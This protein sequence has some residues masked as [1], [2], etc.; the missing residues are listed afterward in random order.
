M[1]QG[2]RRLAAL[3]WLLWAL[4]A[5]AA[6]AV[7]PSPPARWAGLV[8]PLFHNLGSQQGLGN[9]I[10]TALAQDRDGFL[11]V[12]TQGGL[13]RWDGY[14]FRNY[15]S[16]PG[17]SRTL[18]DNFVGPL[19]V[20]A[21]GRL[22]IGT[23]SGG[24]ARYEPGSDSFVT[25]GVDNA[26]LA[27]PGV[28][29]I[30][31]DGAGGLWVGSDQG[32]DHLRGLADPARTRAAH[33][34]AGGAH[35]LPSKVVK[36]L[37]RD[38]AGTLWVGT[39][40]GLARYDPRLGGFVGVR[41]PT[42]TG[43]APCVDALFQDSDGQLWIGTNG[44][45]LFVLDPRGGA[46][47]RFAPG[48]AAVALMKNESVSAIAE[49]VPGEIW[50]SSYAGG[51]AV[52]NR[53]S[54][55]ARVLSH[56]PRAPA[57]VPSGIVRTVFGDRAG[58]L[59]LGT[60]NGLAQYQPG[61]AAL[62]LG[63]ASPGRAGLA[64]GDVMSLAEAP[65]GRLW[66]GFARRGADLIDPVRGT[67]TPWRQSGERHRGLLPSNAVT[68]LY[69][70]ADGQV[71]LATP[72]GL[73]RSDAG[74][75]RTARVAAPWLDDRWLI[76]TIARTGEL[77]WLGTSAEG[78]FQ[79]RLDRDGVLRKVRHI[80]GLNGA[81]INV[82]LPGPA[83]AGYVWVG[84][85]T[86]LNRVEVASGAVLQRIGADPA[87]PGALSHAYVAALHLDRHGRLWVGGGA[88][89]DV[90]EGGHADGQRRFR[91]LGAAQGL[92]NTN[93]NALLA[94]RA[95]RVWGST[96]DGIVVVD[97][98]SYAVGVI[99]RAEGARYAPYWAGAGSAT[100]NGE[101]VFG[102]SGGL[103]IV[104]PEQY[105]G[106]RLNP[107]VV[108]TEV[109]LGGQ[110][111]P[112]A[113]HN[114]AGGPGLRVAAAANSFAVE[115]AALDFTAPELN[116]YAYRLEGYDRDWIAADA[117]HRVAAY[118]NLPPGQYQLLVR[119]SNRAGLW[120]AHTL[121]I[122]VRVQPW[123]YQT[124]GF[125]ALATALAAGALYGVYRLRIWRLAAQR[126]ALEKEVA[127]RTN[128]VM[129]QKALAEHQ[130]R[131]ASERNAELAT[132]NAV[133]QILAGKLDLEALIAQVGD[134]VRASFAADVTCIALV[135]HDSGALQFRYPDSSPALAACPAHQMC[136]RVAA[137]G[138]G[139]LVVR[140]SHS[141]LCVP[142]IAHGLAQGAVSVQRRAPYK[143]GDQRLLET[144][145]AH[146]GAA[147]QN[148]LLFRQAEAA[149]AR[150]EEATQAKSM[151]LANMSHE[152]RTPMNAVIGLSYL[153]LSTEVPSRQR[154][155][156]QKIHNAGNSLLGI[157]SDILD[158]SKIEAGK[159]EIEHADFDLDDVL[160]HVA[161][162][163]GGG[164]GREGLEC[165]FDVPPEVP[166]ALCGDALRL[167]QVLINLL[168]NA[169]KFTAQ[170]E[171][172]L[173]V[174]VLERQPERVRL[175]FSVRDTGIGMSPAQM[176]RLFQAFTQADGSSTR[177]FGGTGLGLSICKSLV[178]LMGGTIRADSVA[179]AGSRFVVELWLRQARAAAAAPPLPPSLPGLRV[180]VVDD[181][182]TAR[183]ALQGTL[184]GL[185]LAAGTCDSWPDAMSSLAADGAH[186]DL[187]LADATLPGLGADPALRRAGARDGLP[188]R[189]ALLTSQGE[190]EPSAA[191]QALGADAVLVKPVTRAGMADT[192]LQLFAPERRLAGGGVRPRAPQFRGA[193]VLLV[194]DN[195]INQEIAV[196]LLQACGIQVDL[197]ANGADALARLQAADAAHRYQL[198]FMD[199]H[200]PELDGHAA[201]VR[202][203][204]ERRF[205]GLPIIAMT[206]NTLP[207]E[208][209]RCKR[210]GFNDHISKPLI[211]A[212]LHRLLQH[213]LQERHGGWQGHGEAPRTV[214][215]LD[216]VAGLD[217]AQ[218]RRSVN[219]NEA[220]LHKVLRW[221]R[222]DEHDC[223]L[224]IRAA[225]A[226]RDQADA[227][228]QAHA[229]RGLAQGMGAARVEHWA[230]ELELAIRQQPA[231]ESC[232]PAL[233]ALEAALADLCASLDQSLPAARADAAG[234][235]AAARPPAA[236]LAQLR[237][238]A[239]QMRAGDA[240]VAEGFAGCAVE[241]EATFGIWDREALQRSLDKLDFDGAYAALQWV[242]HQH[243]LT[244]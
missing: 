149:R 166:R 81:D 180:L 141:K 73:Y 95:G 60:D 188:P 225:L 162:V 31:D 244:L 16:I 101:L 156:V 192:L 110:A 25:Y 150:A 102:G 199:L 68:T 83:G 45:G 112:P 86:G 52:I 184:A 229:L 84:T 72:S 170:G 46:V 103:T 240:A 137:T 173:A 79:A 204:A 80:E 21:G 193:R 142:I 153:A 230:R 78:L 107:P 88:G 215:P 236:W 134:H 10:V 148:T 65:D 2:W 14:R 163:S 76:H 222:R 34:G 132:V 74:G 172:A 171:V 108:A 54:G 51:V 140:D 15:A 217:L 7:A 124:W 186:V 130:H 216:S 167:G 32:L 198:V 195:Q 56:D 136:G 220:L 39:L 120:S 89:I 160:A 227:L 206:A 50:I 177:R 24:L 221:F 154:D 99:G 133:A 41:V 155:Y 187:V 121:R 67:V 179:G 36:S 228:R 242:A 226:R 37:R 35:G 129:Q 43:L 85:A 33:F 138:I 202:L 66:A 40:H 159:L 210:E 146:I 1:T 47:R 11:W 174:R 114:G 106:W 151:F 91:R 139:E 213:Y 98:D 71:W 70:D 152:I 9:V 209:Q 119:G 183:A 212:A 169:L 53:A 128:E 30:A 219:G 231:P 13:S 143:A 185:G 19:H 201:T 181:N 4:G 115:F 144:I 194:E 165:N 64:D 97:P 126:G 158:F 111:G 205:D 93:I 75:Q 38:A 196:G 117:A 189:I 116:R 104:R 175:A 131:E 59:W 82:V 17:D 6:P 92:P 176:E 109:R 12:G 69:T 241:F 235:G 18:P 164:R 127:A 178:D 122:P 239:A 42:R 168:S 123:W 96:D 20:D 8:Q 49:P 57:G 63:R 113:P 237:R 208:W 44:D 218:A 29:A 232:G 203:R 238:M 3:A 100:S 135:D 207:E 211:L 125:R 5:R 161:A 23:A 197:A 147:L 182:A 105:H 28:L 214:A 87:R 233:A 157:I 200:M 27:A 61:Q 26:G 224:R 118:T 145:A 58:T 243:E 62:S 94:D 55:A 191:A 48:E 234:A 22:W 223:A 77:Y 90:M 190:S